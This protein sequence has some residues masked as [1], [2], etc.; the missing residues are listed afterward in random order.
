MMISQVMAALYTKSFAIWNEMAEMKLHLIHLGSPYYI[1]RTQ[2]D[3]TIS[4]IHNLKYMFNTK[5]TLSVQLS[6]IILHH[7]IS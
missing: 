3:L 6:L 7:L 1:D 5:L 2:I 4:T